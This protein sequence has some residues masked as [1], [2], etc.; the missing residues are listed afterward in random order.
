M[1]IR[2]GTGGKRPGGGGADP[3]SDL[4]FNSLLGISLLFFIAII[5]INPTSKDAEVEIKAYFVITVTWKDYSPD[6][7]DVWVE[8]PLGKK[9]WF[10]QREVGLLHL[11]RDDRGMDDDKVM[12][13]DEMIENPLNQEIVTI[14]GV[15]PGRYTVNLHYYKSKTHKPVEADVKIFKLRPDYKV[16]LDDKVILESKGVEKTVVNFT[17][18]I[19]G[20]LKKMDKKPRRLVVFTNGADQ[21]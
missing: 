14:R 11:D 6:D 16:I 17:L 5:F 20:R 7:I 18:G 4:L 15:Y 21:G 10:R 8:D 19:D 1:A 3:F 12:V 2:A 9:L 13:D